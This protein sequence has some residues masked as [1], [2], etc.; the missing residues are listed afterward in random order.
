MPLFRSQDDFYN[1]EKRDE[2]LQKKK[3][4]GFDGNGI[5]LRVIAA[6]LLI[7]QLMG[8]TNL[9]AFIFSFDQSPTRRMNQST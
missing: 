5:T 7:I 2:N 6:R 1:P 9:D 3:S 8:E 4:L